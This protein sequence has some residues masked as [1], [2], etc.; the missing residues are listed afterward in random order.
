M[1]FNL[2]IAPSCIDCMLTPDFRRARLWRVGGAGGGRGE[3]S[4][5]SSSSAE[6]DE[7]ED[8]EDE[9]E[10]DEPSADEPPPPSS[11]SEEEDDGSVCG[12][13][14]S[15]FFAIFASLIAL[16]SADLCSAAA[17]LYS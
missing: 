17:L 10:N 11:S 14:F 8:D 6:E 12:G 1:L 5:S 16:S 9:E 15:T 3:A 4:P 2:V 13:A 7:E